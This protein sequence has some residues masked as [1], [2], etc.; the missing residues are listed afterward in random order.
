[1]ENV[2]TQSRSPWVSFW[3]DITFALGQFYRQPKFMASMVLC[4]AL[5]MGPNT[6]LFSLINELLLGKVDSPNP[7]QLVSLGYTQG[8]GERPMFLTPVSHHDHLYIAENS[9]HLTSSFVTSMGK[10]SLYHQGKSTLVFKQLVSS[11]FFEVLEHKAALGKTFD[12]PERFTL[13]REPFVVLSHKFWQQQFVGDKDIINQTIVLN[14]FDFKVI[15]VMDANFKG[16]NLGMLPDF[17]V[18]MSMAAQM[19]PD[20]PNM[21]SE[22]NNRWLQFHGRIK[23]GSSVDDLNNELQELSKALVEQSKNP[24]PRTYYA[25]EFE[26]FG[27]LPH[28]AI[29]MFSGALMFVGSLILLLACASVGALLLAKATARRQEIAVRLAMGASRFQVIRQLLIEG[30]ILSLASGAISLIITLWMRK[31]MLG[32][33]PELPVNITLSMPIDFT[34]L[35][36]VICISALTTLIFALVPALQAT[37]FNLMPVLK[38]QPV[39]GSVERDTS[40]LRSIFLVVQFALSIAL[41]IGAATAI[42]SLQQAAEV[43]VGFESKNVLVFNTLL[44]QYGFL[45]DEKEQVISNLKQQFSQVE[46]VQTVGLARQVPLGMDRSGTRAA[47]FDQ[48]S[49]NTQ[50]SKDNTVRINYTP[51]DDKF[52]TALDINF[53]QGRNFLPEDRDLISP[54][55]VI[56]EAAKALF[57]GQ[58]NALGQ[59]IQLSLNQQAF[60]VIGIVETVKSHSIGE[61]DLPFVYIPL[62]YDYGHAISFVIRTDSDASNYI[63]VIKQTIENTEAMIATDG[64]STISEIINFVKIPLLVIATLCG[65]L[66]V[67]ALILAIIGVYGGV[68]YSIQLRKQEVGVRLS[69]GA[70]PNQLIWL[71]LRK[72]LLLALIGAVFG[73]ALGFA[74]TSIMSIVL[75]GPAQQFTTFAAVPALLIMVAAIAILVPAKRTAYQQPMTALRYD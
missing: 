44:S 64:I 55:I 39:A 43:D 28:T 42:K 52:F 48:Q 58:D 16:S 56:N 17:W 65:I 66:G 61:Q 31:A 75:I 32:Y 45:G 51:V 46:G 33:L 6:A 10:A 9:Q 22:P 29:A 26:S 25:T 12:V 57:F 13:G 19:R 2:T 20:S 27:P 40:I 18:P 11:S 23:A 73:V 5:G 38:D 30:M 74:I 21:I 37:K 1:M 15:G 62:S 35:A 69:L 14:G 36:Y 70:S 50:Q 68:S 34:V 67:L 63:D 3:Q 72:G 71:L 49:S 54:V 59:Y 60:E 4:L 8:D 41:L 24:T 47:L 53:L 7:H